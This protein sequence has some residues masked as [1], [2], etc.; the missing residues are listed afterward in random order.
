MLPEFCE[1]FKVVAK[2][3]GLVVAAEA[4]ETK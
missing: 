4:S 1:G 2:V 3:M